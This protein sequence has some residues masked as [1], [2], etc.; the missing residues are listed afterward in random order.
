ML[1]VLWILVLFPFYRLI[2]I[3]VFQRG[4]P[5]TV[6]QR[7]GG[8]VRVM[9]VLG[10]GGH[11]TEM[12]RI[13]SVL[14]NEFGPI[15]VVVAETDRQST[16]MAKQ[17]LIKPYKLQVIPRA[18]EVK[19]TWSSTI[20][21]TAKAIFS[22]IPVVFD[23]RPDLLLLNGPGT[24]I[25]IVIASFCLQLFTNHDVKL[26][27]VESFCRVEKLSLTGLLLYPI[28]D[29]FFVQWPQLLTKYPRALY[30]GRF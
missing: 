10:S 21:S 8:S 27:F 30:R 23:D 28:A 19:Q 26:V 1:A 2:K 22:S 6:A 14:D 4:K 16:F 3:L 5:C 18:R 11:T 9:A 24:C 25:P 15:T 29:V 13:L 20:L 17:K 12:L 7:R